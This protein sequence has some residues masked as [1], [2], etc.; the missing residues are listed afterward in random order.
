[1]YLFSR[2]ELPHLGQE[3]VAQRVAKEAAAI[4]QA[5]YAEDQEAHRRDASESEA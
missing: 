4:E 2:A 3:T 1:M 5:A